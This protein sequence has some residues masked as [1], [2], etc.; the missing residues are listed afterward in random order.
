MLP[1]VCHQKWRKHRLYYMP[2]FVPFVEL[3]IL[4]QEW[5][6]T[7]I[8]LFILACL[9]LLP[10]LYLALVYMY[11]VFCNFFCILTWKQSW[12]F[13]LTNTLS[14]EFDYE[15]FG[16]CCKYYAVCRLWTYIPW[17]YFALVRIFA[18]NLHFSISLTFA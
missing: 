4:V 2:Y 10:V 7:I 15:Y 8:L 18:L 3:P 6:I 16:I 11:I 12:F 1:A 17:L 9:L 13:I 5:C 14:D